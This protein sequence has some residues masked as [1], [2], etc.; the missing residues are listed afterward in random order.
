[1]RRPDRISNPV[2]AGN[3]TAEAVWH[4]TKTVDQVARSMERK[5]GADRL[6]TI[7]APELA[8]KFGQAKAQ[9]DQAILDND[10][11]TTAQKASAMIRGWQALDEEATRSGQT[12]VDAS[13]V[14]HC[15][16]PETG[17]PFIIAAD[18]PTAVAVAQ[19]ASG[20]VYS[21]DE[22]TRILAASTFVNKV[23]AAMPGATVEKVE[24]KEQN[25]L[26]DEIPF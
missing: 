10:P 23:K 12:G 13:K 19:T 16:H 3:E 25:K 11:Q 14:W 22:V 9:L 5:W 8:A 2:D 20:T 6:P 21:I 24:Q 7:V 18:T 26:D 4:A 1:M 15:R 17:Q